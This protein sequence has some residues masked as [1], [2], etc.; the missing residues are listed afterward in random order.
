M[1]T[2]AHAVFPPSSSGQLSQ[3]ALSA[4]MRWLYPELD[5]DT[6]ESREGTA[7]HWVAGEVLKS[8]QQQGV[9]LLTAKQFVGQHD[10]DGWLIDDEVADSAS[11]YAMYVLR[12]VGGNLQNMRIEERVI[13]ASVHPDSWGTPDCWWYDAATKTVQIF[14][15]KHGFGIVEAKQNKQLTHY[16]SGIL[17]ELGV[18]DLETNVAMH[19]VQPR[20]YHPEGI[21][22]CW[23]TGASSLRADINHLSM[24]AY[25]ALSGQARGN[26]GEM[27]KHCA[28][29][30]SCTSL[31]RAA[32]KALDYSTVAMPDVMD[33]DAL[34]IERTIVSQGVKLLEYR[35]SGIDA[36]IMHKGG[37]VGWRVESGQSRKVWNKQFDTET[38]AGIA[39]SL[40]VDVRKPNQLITPRQ[41]ELAGMD[42][43]MVESMTEMKKGKPVLIASSKTKASIIFN[44]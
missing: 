23:R 19:I 30:H 9:S 20:A 16:V 40:G 41:A 35:L 25:E 31:Q 14:D 10:P 8:Y 18:S 34:S 12:N 27:C 26:T 13:C 39:D 4:V 37:V 33:D 42:S 6:N 21:A 43:E 5:G 28:G 32:Y 36:Q 7:A 24:Q 11:E 3:C 1:T 29:R 17:D 22:R 44:K 15:L 38:I 2:S